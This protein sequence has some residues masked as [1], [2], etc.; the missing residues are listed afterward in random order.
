MYIRYRDKLT[1]SEI[2]WIEKSL[3]EHEELE[4]LA[5]WF[6]L[7]YKHVDRFKPVDH[8][9]WSSRPRS[10]EL[11]PMPIKERSGLNRFVL[12]AQSASPRKSYIESLKTFASEKDET[13]L[14]ILKMEEKGIARFHLLSEHLSDEEVALVYIPDERIYLVIHPGG[15]LDIPFNRLGNDVIK[16]WNRCSLMLPVFRSNLNFNTLSDKGYIVAS[17]ETG[18][19]DT[20]DMSRSRSEVELELPVYAEAETPKLLL[21]YSSAGV[22]LW[23]IENGIVRIPEKYLANQQSLFFYS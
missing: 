1:Q 2:E 12:A 9:R 21:V 23:G 13:L 22:T 19:M 18:I 6:S 20:I 17:S 8:I 16:A 15:K 10:I 7:L 3:S 11:L 4:S 14:R 5:N